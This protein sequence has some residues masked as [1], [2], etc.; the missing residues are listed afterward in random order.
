M[1][2]KHYNMN[3]N[4]VDNVVE[5]SLD[6]DEAVFTLATSLCDIN[7]EEKARNKMYNTKKEL[8]SLVGPENVDKAR[9][10][11]GYISIAN[12]TIKK[13]ERA[14]ELQDELKDRFSKQISEMLKE[15]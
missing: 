10:V 5:L 3:T 6:Y 8:T 9:E 11:S 13:L 15:S 7:S 14:I 2:S 1:N 4:R 12:L